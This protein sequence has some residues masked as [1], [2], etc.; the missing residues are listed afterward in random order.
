MGT[1]ED[2]G[3]EIRFQIEDLLSYRDRLLARFP[4]RAE[5]SGGRGCAFTGAGDSMAV[6]LAAEYFSG[7]E[8][9]A[10]HPCEASLNPQFLQNKHLYVISVS[11]RTIANIA[12][13]QLAK[14]H[15]RRVTAITANP[16]SR[17]AHVC[18]DVIQL[19][20]RKTGGLSPGTNSFTTSLLAALSRIGPLPSL[21]RV[22]DA[23]ER[24]KTWA[25]SAP[26]EAAGGTLFFVAAE[27]LYPLA[28]YGAAKIHEVLGR[29]A[30]YERLE[31]FSHME[32][33]SL[34]DADT[35]VLLLR[36]QEDDGGVKLEEALRNLGVATHVLK[37]ERG[38]YVNTCVD[39]AIHLQ[40]LPWTLAVKEG[41]AECAFLVKRDAL[42]ASDRIIY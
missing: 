17:L 34:S 42:K 35:V 22:E 25:D 24:A 1:I 6:A 15:A 5:E 27:G 20:F 36:G 31:Q 3:V 8:A 21:L 41:V 30:Q 40:V 11:G 10:L 14:K 32:L 9:R 18:D 33:F 23:Y 19:G 13:A 7:F 28:L 16:E 39:A 38:D 12:A 37:V 29:K 26:V 2:M 4:S